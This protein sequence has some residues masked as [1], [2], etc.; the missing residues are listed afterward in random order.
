MANITIIGMR[1]AGK[2]NVS[3]RLSVFTKRPVFATDAM[4]SYE[5]GGRSIDDLV[6][7]EGWPAFREREAAVL[8]KVLAMDEIIVDAGGGL[9]M[10][11]DDEGRE[12]CNDQAIAALQAAGPVIWLRGDVPRLVAKVQAKA[13]RPALVNP[14]A[15][16][17]LMH[18]RQPCYEAA[19]THII[20]IEGKK[21]EQIAMEILEQ[22]GMQ[23]AGSP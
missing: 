8:A 23:P 18:A 3:R 6:A 2:S 5:A 11:L 14:V 20:D 15:L 7:E 1:G 13:D 16:M 21:R 10:R 19:A 22:L 17:A 4:V 12:H 9:V